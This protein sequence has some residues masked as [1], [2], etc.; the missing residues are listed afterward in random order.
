[1]NKT[2]KNIAK[3]F[4]S[5]IKVLSL[6]FVAVSFCSGCHTVEGVGE[7]MEAA[8]EALDSSAERSTRY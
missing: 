4:K 8:G 7:D 3:R 1:M 6:L 2:K 5:T